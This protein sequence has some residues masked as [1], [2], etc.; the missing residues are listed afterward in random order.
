MMEEQVRRARAEA[1]RMLRDVEA[2][3]AELRARQQ[4]QE[5]ERREPEPE[6][7]QAR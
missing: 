1:E 2:R 4:E 5:Q 3:L 7:E 6:P